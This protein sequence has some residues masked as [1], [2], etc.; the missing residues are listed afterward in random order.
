MHLFKAIFVFILV[1]LNKTLALSFQQKLKAD[2]S[3]VNTFYKKSEELYQQAKYDSLLNYSKNA[4][5]FFVG[6][7][8]WE[9]QIKALNSISEAHLNLANN[10]SVLQILENVLKIIQ[11]KS[12]ANYEELARTYNNFGF[13]YEMN[14]EYEKAIEFQKKDL[15]ITII[16]F[17]ENHL[18][19]AYSY[20]N[21]GHHYESLAL[22]DTA[23]HYYTK[24]LKIELVALGE[25]HQY[26]AYAYNNIGLCLIDLGKYNQALK[27]LK[28][29]LEIELKTLGE[30]HPHTA[31]TYSNIG[32][33]LVRLGKYY[34][35]LENYKKAIKIDLNTLGENHPNL[36]SSYSSMGAC[37]MNLG[38]YNKAFIYHEKALSIYLEAFGILSRE[39]ATC[40]SNIGDYW[41]ETGNYDE[42]INNYTKSLEIDLKIFA[43]DHPDISSNYNNIGSCLLYKGKSN[44]ALSYY[45]KSLQMALKG[46]GKKHPK[47]AVSYNNIG[48]CFMEMN[49][50]EI[51][52]D[53]FHLALKIDYEVYGR[54]HPKTNTVLSNIGNALLN[55]KYFDQA[56]SYFKKV[57]TYDYS[58]FGQY[59]PKIA[60]TL[61]NIA[62]C[63]SNQEKYD[64]ALIYHTKALKVRIKSLGSY[65][66]ETAE[67]YCNIAAVSHQ[68]DKVDN[69]VFFA[70]KAIIS[71]VNHFKN[72]DI[73][74]N[75][76]LENI[77]SKINLLIALNFKATFLKSL[78][79]KKSERY[80]IASF[81]THQLATQLMDTLRFDIGRNNIQQLNDVY[82]EVYEGSIDTAHKLFQNTNDSSYLYLAFAFA[83]KSK[84]FFLQKALRENEA[85]YFANIPDSLIQLEKKLK[86]ERS[87]YHKK[88]MLANTQKDSSKTALFQDYF[89]LKNQQ[90]DSLII[91]LESKYPQ[92]YE[93]KYKISIPSVNKLQRDL[94]DKSTSLIEYFVGNKAVFI[95]VIK[96]NHFHFFRID[97]NPLLNKNIAS[98]RH[99]ISEYRESRN[100]EFSI[101]ANQLWKQ[102]IQPIE[103]VI[104][105]SKDRVIPKLIIIPDGQL[106]YLPFEV[107]IEEEKH[108]EKSVHSETDYKELPYLIKK[109]TISYSLSANLWASNLKHE[110]QRE[111][112]CLAFAPTYESSTSSIANKGKLDKLRTIQLSNLPGALKEV[113]TIAG[114]AEGNF[115]YGKDATE[116]N[117]KKHADKYQVIH[118]SMH[119]IVDDDNPDNSKL[120]FASSK[121]SIQDNSL[122]VYELY[123]MHIPSD[124][125]VLSACETGLGKLEQGE[126]MISLA[127]AFIYAGSPSLV[128]SLWN[129]SDRNTAPIMENFYRALADGISK[130]E[131]LRVAKLKYIESADKYAAHPYFWSA[132][133]P[134]G[135]MYPVELSK[136]SYTLIIVLGLIITL[137]IFVTMKLLKAR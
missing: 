99:A 44:E 1:F 43:K 18:N 58:I 9:G 62:T 45:Q 108:L 130:D 21:L 30:N 85:K 100:T 24:A 93:L 54:N 78:Y 132:F 136:K 135:N 40:Y 28:K 81:K 76:K 49:K 13:Y 64:T 37:L 68:L 107:L 86:V 19:T 51:A 46:L 5:D 90:I 87:F 52:L 112:Q 91:H 105:T 92:Y 131:A 118:L 88:L 75:P 94:H 73:F 128:M 69:S 103:N 55:Q 137:M 102:L 15:N 127:R 96:K 74:S 114:L 95:F 59:H 98:L 89:F 16:A 115:F 71:T 14:D 123:N 32:L 34:L 72:E 53:Y 83:E 129:I 65:H 35:A 11:S 79:N 110:A 26:T 8:N 134:M 41:K 42:A 111:A 3:V 23:I 2:T 6:I 38:A 82:L 70:Q 25:N 67:S 10:D 47:V 77:N 20:N 106:H 27:K 63:Y 50:P 113:K 80:L 33:C 109:F 39:V 121:D 120:L 17:G 122:H 84:T 22:Y 29:A 36:A 57:V 66:P 101:Y 124:L 133:I 7:D 60:I 12:P 61:N 4:Y 117:F 97:K 119:G 48:T 31:M 116:A 56:L 126:G 125:I 104:N